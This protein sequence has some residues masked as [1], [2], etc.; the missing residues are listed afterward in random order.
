MVKT[1]TH[2]K[3]STFICLWIIFISPAISTALEAEEI[4]I[5]ANRNARYSIGL[6]QYY[7]K[8]RD[9]PE[10]NLIKLWITDKEL[11]SRDDFQKKA[12]GPVKRY[13]NEKDPL[14]IIHCIAV[15]YGL[16]LKVAPPEMT[17]DEKKKLKLL[18]EKRISLEKLIKD[19][20]RTDNK[21]SNYNNEL[22]TIKKEIAYTKKTDQ[23][24]SFDSENSLILLTILS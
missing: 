1:A 21:L 3:L 22:K 10:S 13:F 7:M 4:L 11:C 16:P 20:E 2:L 23:G 6:A 12:V 17:K 8:K 19:L 5:L 15:F 14:K 24:A 18:E 9:I